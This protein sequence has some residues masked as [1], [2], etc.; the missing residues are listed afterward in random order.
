V[1]IGNTTSQLPA[2]VRKALLDA[3]GEI[4]KQSKKDYAF[5][6]TRLK[7]HLPETPPKALELRDQLEQE[8]Q[9]AAEGGEDA[10]PP[11]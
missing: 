10:G 5:A 7:G 8:S 6:L 2:G 11:F 1:V 4:G 3:L 9:G